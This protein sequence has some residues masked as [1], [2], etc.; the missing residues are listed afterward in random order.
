[1]VNDFAHLNKCGGVA[2][3]VHSSFSLKRLDTSDFMQNST[4][5]E[6]IFLEIYNNNYKYKKYIFGSL[7]RRPSQLVAD[8]TQFTEKFSETLAKIHAN[9]K[10]S[11]IN[12]DYS[13]DCIYCTFQPR[14]SLS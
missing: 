9:C 10:Q 2:I 3:Y 5:Y 12:G 14:Y 13:G 11:Y 8:I 7:H 1:M 4:V 6:A